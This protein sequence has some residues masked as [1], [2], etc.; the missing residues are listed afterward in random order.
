MRMEIEV[1]GDAQVVSGQWRVLEKP[2]VGTVL[3]TD[4]WNATTELRCTA[5][6][7]YVVTY[8]VVYRLGH[9]E[10]QTSMVIELF[11]E[12]YQIAQ[13]NLRALPVYG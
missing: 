1:V 5:P 4:P 9:R 13:F 6:G 2:S 8:E 3:V 10:V 11:V 7:R 12:P